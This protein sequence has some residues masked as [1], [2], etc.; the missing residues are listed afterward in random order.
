MLIPLEFQEPFFNE[1]DARES[2]TNL[3]E[4]SFWCAHAALS[5]AIVGLNGELAVELLVAEENCITVR[6]RAKRVTKTPKRLYKRMSQMLH[7]LQ[8]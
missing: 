7:S 8:G 3:N 2:H 5:S 6:A 1:S 4:T